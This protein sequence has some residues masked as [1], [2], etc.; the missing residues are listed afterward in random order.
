MAYSDFVVGLHLCATKLS[1]DSTL[2]NSS[3]VGF[4]QFA[5]M[6]AHGLFCAAGKLV[7]YS[8]AGFFPRDH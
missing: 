8:R 6:E 7:L 2:L 4:N 5:V 3:F 1:L